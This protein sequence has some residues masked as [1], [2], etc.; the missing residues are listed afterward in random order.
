[1]KIRSVVSLAALAICVA[2]AAAPARAQQTPCLADPAWFPHSQTKPPD[3]AQFPANPN[4]CDFHQW[5]WQMFLWLTQADASGQPRFLAFA[6]PESLRP[7]TPAKVTTLM[8]GLELTS[9]KSLDAYLQAGPDGILVD[10]NG[11]IV[12]YSIYIDDVFS[13]FVTDNKLNT[14]AGLRGF[15]PNV[16]FPVGTL[17]LKAAWKVV[18]PNEQLSGYFTRKATINPLVKKG[19]D[20]YIDPSRTED[21]TVA[22]VGFHIAGTVA[23]HAEMIWASFEN[24]A[25]APDLAVS[26][27]NVTPDTIVSDKDWTFYKAKTPFS[28]CNVNP[29]GSGTQTLDEK[30]QQ[31]SPVTQVCR[32]YPYG[33][34]AD[35]A[36]NAANIQSINADT[37][38]RLDDVW[39]NY[40]EIGA[41]WFDTGAGKPLQPECSFQPGSLQCGVVVTGSTHLSNATI[42]TFTQSQSVLDNCFACHNTVQ[43]F[44][45]KPD[46]D[47]LPGKNVAISHVLNNLYFWLEQQAKLTAPQSPR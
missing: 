1:M 7:G 43:R 5:S 26:L 13:K 30:T 10:Q 33:S 47:P 27:S 18:G 20:F 12:Y 23:H 38:K 46:L 19:N 37:Q 32:L 31:M 34:G 15:D 36:S 39:K 25:N 2:A 24:V 6:G 29:A 35:K 42:E 45:P 22:L 3:S 8:P 41:I 28:G 17:S 44:A 4:N 16:A 40:F 21:V 14:I 9:S 11:R